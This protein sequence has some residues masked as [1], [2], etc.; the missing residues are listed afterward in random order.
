MISLRHILLCALNCALFCLFSFK[1]TEAQC[2]VEAGN[3]V[4]ICSGQSVT[5]GGTPTISGNVGA[6]TYGWSNS[7]GN[8]P[9]PSVSPATTTTYTLNI[10][11][12][13]CQGGLNDQV[14]VTVLP[15][16]TASFTFGPNNA[17]AGTTVNFVSNVA[18]CPSCEYEWN[19]GDPA[20]GASNTSTLSNP[21]HIFNAVGNGNTN[22]TVTLTVTAANGCETT[23]T[24]TV[25]VK[26]SPN[27]VLTEDVNFTQC[28]GA[29]AFYAFVQNASVP[30]SN[31]NYTINWGDGSPNYNSSSPP[32]SLEHIY[33]GIDIW[34]LT[35]TVTGTNGCSDVQEYTVTNISNPALG[36]FNSGNTLQCGPA[37][38]CFDV[39]GASANFS[40]VTYS[41]N[42]GD[43]TP[44]VTYT[45]DQLTAP[46]CHSYSTPS[47]PGA[48]T[49]TV[50]ANTNC[51]TS[52]E[53][54][55]TPI[56]IFT[57]PSA[58]FTNP[59][60]YCVG[61]AVPFTNTSIPGYNQNC[62]QNTSYSWNFG[63]PASGAS[64]TSTA[65]SPS[66]VYNTPGT[67][68]ITMT[69]AN[70]GNPLLACP[71]TTV[72]HT[73]C[74]EAPPVPAIAVNN[75]TGCVPMAVTT[76]NTSTSLNTC[77]VSSTWVIDYS[78]LPCMPNGGAYTYTGGTSASSLQ[79]N[80]TLQ[81]E[82]VYTIRYRMENSCGIFQDF[83]T[84]TVNTVPVVDV[85]TPINGVCAGTSGTASAVVNACSLPVTYA[86]TFAGGS[87]ANSSATTPP[88]VTYATAGN[89]NV[90]LAVTNSCGTTTDVAVMNV[91]NIP[92]VQ[93]TATNNDLS[94]CSGQPTILTATGAATYTWSPSTYLSNYSTSGNTV[95][96]SPTAGITYTVTGTSGSCTDTGTITLTVDPLPTIT[97][98]G[99]FALCAGETELL[100]VNVTGGTGPYS[101][102]T[103]SPNSG[104]TAYNI[105]APTFNGINSTTYTV[106]VTDNNGCPGTTSVPVVVNPLPPTNAGPDITLCSQPVATQLTGFS[107]TTGGTG[108]WSGPGVTPTGVFTPSG[109]GQVTLQYC[110][111]YTTTGCS[112]C[113]TRI[114]DVTDPTAANGGPDTTF[115]LNSA[116]YQLPLGSWSGSLQVTSTGL[117]TP[118]VVGPHN[119]TVLQGT[120]SCQTT[121]QVVITV[122]PLPVAN[123]GNDVTICV[124]AT[125]NLTSSCTSC[126]NGPIDVCSW[127]GSALSS[128][129]SCNPTATPTTTTTYNLIVVDDAGCSD[130]DQV[131]VFVNPLPATNA[132]PDLTICNQ[133]I[134]TLLNGTPAGG[135]WTGPN[136]TTSGS[137]TPTAT[138]SFTLTYSYTNP[139]TNCNATDQVI[140]QVNEPVIANAGP[141]VT[142]CQNEGVYQLTGFAPASGGIWSGTGVVSATNGTVQSEVAGVGT[143]I[144]TLTNGSGTCLTTDQMELTILPTPVVNAGPGVTLCGNA[145]IF[146]LTGFSPATGGTWEGTGITNP[147]TG[148]FDPA[149]GTAN[150][151]LLY[152]FENITTGCRD[153]STTTVIVNSAPIANFNLATQGCTN[154]ALSYLNTSVGGNSY[155]WRFGNG[156]ELTGFQPTYTYPNPGIFQ[157]TQIV[158]NLAGCRDTAF[159]TTEIINPPLANLVLTT[160]EGCAPLY[161]PFDNQ[162][163]G[164]YMTYLW[165]LGTTTSTDSLPSPITYQQGADVLTYPISLTV[166]NYCG[167]TSDN[168]TVTILPQPQA[169]FGTNLD[170][171]C[172]PFTVLFNNTSTGLPDTYEWDFGDGTFGYDEE[173]VSHGYYT[174]DENTDYTIWLYLENECGRDTVNYTIT[175]WPNTITG[176]FNTNVLEGCEPLEVEFTDHSDGATQISYYL[177]DGYGFTSDDN[178]TQIYAAGE[179]TIYQ[180][181][182]NGCSYDTTSITITVYDAPDIDFT[183]NVPTSCTHNEV[184]FIPEL[185]DAIEVFWDFGDGNTSGLSSPSHEYE[186]GGLY[187]VTMTGLSDNNCTTTVTHP[188]NIIPGPEA[189]FTMPDIVGCSPFQ[190]CFSNT[191][192]AGNFYTW[193]FGDGNTANGQSPCHTYQNI[194]GTAL[195]LTVQLIA[196]DIQLCADTFEVNIVVSPQPISAFTLT[197]FD[198]CLLPQTLNT[199][200]ISQ[201]ANGY[202]WL[203]NT[204]EIS[205]FINTTVTFEEIGEYTISLVA[206]NQFGCTSTSST[207]YEYEEL[208]EAVLSANPRQGC[209]PLEVSFINESQNASTYLWTLGNGVVSNA[210]APSFTYQIP[211]VYDITLVAYNNSGCT[212]TLFADDYI[213]AFSLPIAD[214]WLD[215]QETDVYRSTINFHDA[216][217]NAYTWQWYFGD[218]NGSNEMNPVYTYPDAGLWPVTLT[219]WNMYGCQSTKRDV[220]IVNDIFNVFVPNTFTPD[221]DGINEVFL[222][223]LSG[224]PF[225]NKYVF[226]IFDRWGTLIFETTDFNEA[227]TGDVREGEFY[228]KDDA[229]NWQVIIQLKGSDE[230]RTYQGHVF[231]LR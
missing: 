21:S 229:Y 192:T 32:S 153:S 120:G 183:T 155:I 30:A 48:Y 197:N 42:F 214:F 156:T 221:G 90:T 226:R 163:V 96:S 101:N 158:E 15:A 220:V 157:I 207:T 115:C 57:G 140:I 66:H 80:I 67:Y 100:G 126:P 188:F 72:T 56:Q 121:D 147:S 65:T 205:T 53:A 119:L 217:F 47:C 162:S 170:A 145:A 91:L 141:D 212:D 69:A 201:F 113:D 3:N 219:V 200:N 117:F 199:N 94:I 231:I 18:A 160:T 159:N 12:G 38:L 81:S 222:P 109:N 151:T 64:N 83:E 138:G 108:T 185:D 125:V 196:Q 55:Y 213:R 54:S 82:G 195:P 2:T 150:N 41:V 52:S 95:T 99:T 177:G 106:S 36:V 63:D 16:P 206:S 33:N 70:G 223:Q 178:P 35:Y 203:L 211:G 225:I 152:W 19:F 78:E 14:T 85:S 227:W 13:N 74:I 4:T 98:S 29:S 88:A 181:A 186:E 218:G 169:S 167:S 86:W 134:A 111:Q 164:Q 171:F 1:K 136:V 127:T 112:A 17:C 224:K 139:L 124:G 31:S 210:T 184:H 154:S 71:P 6:V 43:G 128:P 114:I 215:P 180:Y 173:P 26:Q 79:P 161:V 9:N 58:A 46:V 51:P 60:N 20:S 143:H 61:A 11:G 149:L 202:Q 179:H 216:S 37:M 168:A 8:V 204:E 190:V 87:P 10:T 40:E 189:S 89:H 165:N 182:D 5:L 133:P 102:Y 208:P 175:V 142:L 228:A 129:L 144:I 92:D 22:F 198:P 73:V 176:F 24:Q 105:Q 191:T 116:S 172:S 23:V 50:S 148:T 122:L 194:G 84:V 107:P 104:L 146:N 131:T 49:F 25:I 59:P 44:I 75:L 103:W 76:T 187:I 118:S 123:A 230:E 135:S 68:T 93:I 166:T 39:T 77:N 28:V 132:G 209:I 97:P 45:Q 62:S 193:N 7:L 137:F 174:G 110:F 27:A 130:N 34:T